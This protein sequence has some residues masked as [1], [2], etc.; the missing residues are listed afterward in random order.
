MRFTAVTQRAQRWH[1]E[2]YSNLCAISVSS[3]VSVVSANFP[4]T[5]LKLNHYRLM[6]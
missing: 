5:L 6:A 3:P 4:F 2:R 1:R